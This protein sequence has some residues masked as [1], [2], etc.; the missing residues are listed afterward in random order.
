MTSTVEQSVEA[1]FTAY[2]EAWRQKDPAAIAE[3]HAEDG[4]LHLHV[5]TPPAVGRAAV[6][7]SCESLFATLDY[8]AAPTRIHFGTDHW[9]LE[10]TMTVGEHLIDCI[11]VIAMS[12][13]GLVARKDGYVDA[14]QAAVVLAA[15]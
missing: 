1:T 10:W 13:D 5:G 2:V 7:A 4:V 12:P 9:V 14:A 8:E 6:R 3:L 15:L 11:D